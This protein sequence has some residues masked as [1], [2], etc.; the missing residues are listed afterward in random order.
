MNK[1]KIIAT[2]QYLPK[3]L[4][5]HEEFD[6]L[7][8]LEKGTTLK[9]SG[10]RYRHYIENESLVEMAK[11]AVLDAIKDSDFDLKEL[12][13]IVFAGGVAQQP[14]P[15]SASLIQKEL[16][17]ENS[18]IPCFD[19]NS[20]CLSFVVAFDTISYLI[21][22]NKYKKVLI[23]SSDIASVGINYNDFNS[24]IL[25]GD[26]A[27]AVIVEKS[28]AND[29]S[30]IINFN[31]KTFSSGADFA[32]ITG[33]G[34]LIHPR[35]Y[36]EKTKEN[37]LFCMNGAKIYESASKHI[38][39][40][41]DDTLKEANLTIDDIKLVIPHQASL[42]SMKLVQRKLKI[43]QEKFLY[44]IENQGNTIASSIP[45]CLDYAIKNNLIK[46]KDKVVLLGT[47]AGLSIGVAVFEY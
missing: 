38:K 35:N 12:D 42:M 18:S 8:N 25:F 16:G 30:K 47:S 39:Q 45:L 41:Y 43:P 9:K 3:K 33:G 34:S 46:R 1:I 31:L 26:G 32:K 44:N 27:A 24:A 13:C 2:G 37:F 40:I 14:I 7:F 10:V 21:E 15:C 11:Y 19:I 36:S 22:A 5:S 4:K 17:L 23:V 28:S 6:K 20:T 29:S